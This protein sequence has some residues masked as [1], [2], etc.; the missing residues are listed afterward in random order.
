MDKD[1]QT[2]MLQNIRPLLNISGKF[3]D[4]LCQLPFTDGLY[5]GNFLRC[6]HAQK[7]EGKA[8]DLEA[9]FI[10]AVLQLKSHQHTDSLKVFPFLGTNAERSDRKKVEPD[11]LK[12]HYLTTSQP[13]LLELQIVN[14]FFS[15]TTTKP[16]L[17][18]ILRNYLRILSAKRMQIRPRNSSP[19]QVRKLI[20]NCQIHYSLV[21][22]TIQVERI[23]GG[24][25]T[26][27]MVSLDTLVS[28]FSEV[29]GICF[30]TLG[31]LIPLLL[32]VD[33]AFNQMYRTNGPNQG[34]A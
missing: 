6:D 32:F 21:A 5:T 2:E 33:C 24:L 30:T 27:R 18:D 14:L 31:F 11:Y 25:S 28:P 17:K 10:Q 8:N 29:L 4:E 20:L 3:R 22:F 34:N 23:G 16:R 13:S 12:V 26:S 15:S 9:T 7:T 1:C 19:I